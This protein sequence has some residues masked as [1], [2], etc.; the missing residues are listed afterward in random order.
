[1]NKLASNIA[2]DGI[3][4]V[5]NQRLTERNFD[6]LARNVVASGIPQLLG[7]KFGARPWTTAM[8]LTD[9]IVFSDAWPYNDGPPGTTR[10]IIQFESAIGRK[11]YHEFAKLELAGIH[12]STKPEIFRSGERELTCDNMLYADV[13]TGGRVLTAL[14]REEYGK[15]LGRNEPLIVQHSLGQIKKNGVNLPP[16]LAARAATQRE[17]LG[18]AAEGTLLTSGMLSLV[19]GAM[20][21]ALNDRNLILQRPRDNKPDIE[22]KLT[23]IERKASSDIGL[24]ISGTT[25]GNEV[26]GQVIDRV[27][28]IHQEDDPVGDLERIASLLTGLGVNEGLGTAAKALYTAT[29]AFGYAFATRLIDQHTMRQLARAGRHS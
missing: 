4:G 12:G 8:Y 23:F 21:Y 27:R 15:K 19:G 5:L 2:N 13:A 11:H 7:S 28:E 1:M 29:R 6:A 14:F 3:V 22:K 20:R 18:D 24:P 25:V 17:R 26:K 10:S 9:E 16:D